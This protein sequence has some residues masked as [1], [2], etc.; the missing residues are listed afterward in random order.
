[1]IYSSLIH[2]ATYLTRLDKFSPQSN[3]KTFSSLALFFI[4]VIIVLHQGRSLT[5]WQIIMKTFWNLLPMSSSCKII[6]NTQIATCYSDTKHYNLLIWYKT[7][8]APFLYVCLS[9]KQ[10]PFNNLQHLSQ[11]SVKNIFSFYTQLSKQKKK[12]FSGFFWSLPFRFHKP[13]S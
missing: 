12:T 7:F 3:C 6:H 10:N 5:K 13:V 4:L 2:I 11:S 1:M 9:S 8:L